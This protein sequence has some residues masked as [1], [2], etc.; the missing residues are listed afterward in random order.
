MN[1]TEI[2]RKITGYLDHGAADALPLMKSDVR[3]E[4]LRFVLRDPL[5]A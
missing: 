3:E 1:E 5:C 4:S 2:A